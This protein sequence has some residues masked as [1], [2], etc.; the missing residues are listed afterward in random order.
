MPLKSL[1]LNGFKSFAD[2]TKIEFTSGITGIVGPNG[3]GKSNITEGIRWVMGEQSAKSLRGDKMVDIIFA[4]SSVRSTMNR[5]E[6]IFEFDNSK[7][8]LKTEFDR[9]LIKRRLFR[10][11]SSE[12]YINNK[13]CRLKDITELFLDSGLGRESFSIISQG[14]V[15]A[16]FNSKPVDR[17][18]IIEESAGVAL[19][20]QKKHEAELKLT[21]TD[22]N[23]NRVSDIL[24]EL[25]AQVEPLK[26]QASI[27]HDYL[28]QK[29]QYD[30]IYKEILAIEINDFNIS[31]QEF[32]QKSIDIKNTLNRIEEDVRK[33]DIAVKENRAN[34]AK[35]S[36]ELDTKN[37]VLLEKTR[38]LEII[39]GQK[40]VTDERNEFNNQNRQ[41]LEE[42]IKALTTETNRLETEIEVANTEY[43]TAKSE[44]DKLTEKLSEITNSQNK[45]PDSIREE[46]EA[47]RGDYLNALQEQTTNNNNVNFLTTQKD[48]IEKLIA[49]SKTDL[50]Q[51]SKQ[52]AAKQT[53]IEK[54][55][56][57]VT[58]FDQNNLGILNEFDKLKATD[59]SLTSQITDSE[60]QYMNELAKL[61]QAIA[62]K[63]ALEELSNDHAGF[64]QGVKSVL[65]NKQ[66]LSGVIGAVAELI[67]VPKEYQM[68]VEVASGNQLQSIVTKD[69][70]AA[71]SAI[72]YLR[73][74]NLGRATFLPKD[75]IKSR[76][77]D[78][79]TLKSISNKGFLGVASDLVKYDSDVKNIVE[80][81]FG[82]LLIADNL[83][84]A[85][86]IAK[87]TGHRFRI[88]TL[89]GDILSPGGSLTGGQVKQRGNS[90]LSRTQELDDL[91]KIIDKLQLKADGLQSQLN[92]LK[93]DKKAS[94][95]QLTLRQKDIQ[96]VDVKRHDFEQKLTK[97]TDELHRLEQDISSVEYTIRTN[98]SELD[99][100]VKDLAENKENN[101]LVNQKLKDIKEKTDDKNDLL[102]NFGKEQ[103][104]INQRI[105]TYQTQIAV[106]NNTLDNKK[107]LLHRQRNEF[108]KQSNSLCQAQEQL[109]SLNNEQNEIVNS[110]A[111]SKKQ[112]A[113][114]TDE[115]SKLK[116]DIENLRSTRTELESQ[117]DE[118]AQAASRNFQLQKNAS[119]E[120][121]DTAIALTKANNAIDSRLEI[122]SQEYKT[123]FEEAF[124]EVKDNDIDVEAMKKDAK[125][126]KMGIAELGDVN[127]ASITEYDKVKD[128]YEFLNKQQADLLDAREQLKNTMSEMDDE[129]SRRFKETFD[130]VAA[131]FEV[132][133][134]EMFAGGRAKLV[135]TDP[136]DLLETGIEIIAQPPGKKFQRLSL[137]S[138]GERALTAIT[139]LFA[140]IKVKPVPF[141]ILDEVEAALDD[142]N[143]YR[144][145][146]YLNKYDDNTQFIVITHRKGT[147]MNVNR[148]YGVSMEELGVSK[149]VSVE[150][151]ENE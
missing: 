38:Q 144:F 92:Q 21:D 60:K 99:D 89:A 82:N 109:D 40:A 65:N 87:A 35:L 140:I 94:E 84:N 131:S 78:S 54:F 30:K 23:L 32:S 68:A 132:I 136:D 51:I 64:F 117:S 83:D 26:E 93:T 81:I 46:I 4:G 41:Q 79:N 114:L 9:V 142:A 122:L 72:S 85:V 7:Q 62:K 67:Q 14:R 112:L 123:T 63:K 52:K 42:Q 8:D 120:Q 10:D 75:I 55:K 71:K 49:E 133:F 126:L 97:L 6:V 98:E 115:V 29:E 58:E 69:E 90:L 20:K 128:R 77:I 80:N 70:N 2:K 22:D 45:T 74:G 106:A 39:N 91:K 3:S 125:L 43:E 135:L 66:Q 141:C 76:K 116:S 101:T 151:K 36:E 27:A 102:E 17:R 56:Q 88:V 12:F 105:Q 139:L 25:S 18:T 147:M 28:N 137:L 86:V 16:I 13:S 134:P 59:E 61:Q 148:L 143:V 118:L 96:E 145:A 24:H 110:H 100:V 73:K 34:I 48:R 19:Y 104:V 146:K 5:A 113:E 15:E 31:R 107:D 50:D 1:T 138:G 108:K 37:K 103:E 121:E 150:V 124:A 129:V 130:Q 95:E 53:E 111:D 57:E 44:V 33:S 149:M 47:L 11:G 119:D 127:I